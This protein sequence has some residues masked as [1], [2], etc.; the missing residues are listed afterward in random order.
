MVSISPHNSLALCTT[1][2]SGNPERLCLASKSLHI[3]RFQAVCLSLVP[4]RG[5]CPWC[6]GSGNLDFH[7]ELRECKR[8]IRKQPKFKFGQGVCSGCGVHIRHGL[9]WEGPY[10]YI[11]RLHAANAINRLCPLRGTS[12][13][14]LI[15]ALGWNKFVESMGDIP[16]NKMTCPNA[17][18]TWVKAGYDD[19]HGVN[20]IVATVNVVAH[21]RGF[22]WSLPPNVWVPQEDNSEGLFVSSFWNDMNTF[23]IACDA[24]RSGNGKCSICWS[25]GFPFDHDLE[26]CPR[27]RSVPTNLNFDQD[28]CKGCGVHINLGW[29]NFQCDTSCGVLRF[30]LAGSRDENCPWKGTSIPAAC[31]ALGCEAIRLQLDRLLKKAQGNVPTP[32]KPVDYCTEWLEGSRLDNDWYHWVNP[33]ALTV[34]STVLVRG[35]P[36][37]D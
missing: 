29:Y 9:K 35:L 36:V 20:P 8:R 25:G 14:V 34:L 10:A 13:V 1:P 17:F 11:T 4:G 12:L 18:L 16:L 15:G 30:H 24:L 37:N 32:L 3:E 26:D 7:H 33:I 27:G 19:M 28:I 21:L 2:D 5:K 6:W 23:R 22:P 31:V